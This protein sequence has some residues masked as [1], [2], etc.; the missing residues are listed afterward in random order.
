MKVNKNSWHYRLLTGEIFGI[1]GL[2]SWNVSNSL[3]VYFWQ[4]VFVLLWKGVALFFLI[5]FVINGFLIQPVIFIFGWITT[6]IIVKGDIGLTI[7][8]MESVVITCFVIVCAGLSLHTF[9]KN[10]TDLSEDVEKE[11]NIFVE[12][13]KAK[14]NK[15]CPMIEFVE[16]KE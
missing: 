7:L 3:C 6:G 9:L 2:N 5:P 13:V 1:E 10:K 14:K 15:L 8:I 12:Y 11:P 16:D 4:V